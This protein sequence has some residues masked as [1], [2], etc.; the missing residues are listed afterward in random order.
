MIDNYIL[1]DAHKERLR[2]NAKPKKDFRPINK[3]VWEFF[4][5]LYGGG[6]VIT[7]KGKAI[8]TSYSPV[9]HE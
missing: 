9:V 2:P 3:S 1:M 8:L 6:P 4:F 5:H 7:L